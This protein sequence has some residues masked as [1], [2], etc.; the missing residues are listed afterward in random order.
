MAYSFV[1]YTSAGGQTYNV[2]FPYLDADHVKVLINGVETTAF[3]WSDAAT[4]HLNAAPAVGAIILIKRETPRDGMDKSFSAQPRLKGGDLDEA[5]LQAYYIGLEALD[6]TQLDWDA[7][8]AKD[9]ALAAQAAAEAAADLAATYT[10]NAGAGIYAEVPSAPTTAVN[11]VKMYAKETSGTTELFIRKENNG[12]EV[13]VTSGT[14]LSVTDATESVAGLAELATQAEVDAGTDDARIVTPK[15]LADYAE[16]RGMKNLLINGCMRVCQRGS[17]PLDVQTRYGLDRWYVFWGASAGVTPGTQKPTSTTYLETTSCM[18]LAGLTCTGTNSI[19]VNQRIESANAKTFLNGVNHGKW[20]GQFKFWHNF[21]SSVN[22]YLVI[23]SANATDNFSAITERYVSSA[24]SVPTSTWTSLKFEGID[25]PTT[26]MYNGLQFSI[27]IKT[28]VCS[29]KTI[30]I[31]DAQFEIGPKCTTI[32]RRPYGLELALCQRYYEK[33][34]D[35]DTVPGTTTLIGA[36]I[37]HGGGSILLTGASFKVRK[38]AIPTIVIYSPYDG[39][40][41]R[42]AYYNVY[43]AYG[44]YLS[45]CYGSSISEAG[46]NMMGPASG[47]SSSYMFRFHWTASA[48]L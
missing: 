3:T 37:Q 7:V 27:K 34:Y 5:L 35:L 33:S 48:E 4:I 12:S 20:S 26:D 21:G 9:L 36:P 10:G 45:P 15:K 31:G 22:V 18:E 47:F 8:E 17:Q 44:S 6:G 39:A 23:Y 1:T 46:F 13:Q 19:H 29:G 42:V 41:D 16:H 14:G 25:I 11:E 30:R 40:S 24:Q 38:R 2:P 32:E 28:P 43:D